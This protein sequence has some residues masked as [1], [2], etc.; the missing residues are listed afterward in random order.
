MT[1]PEQ[2][3]R[4]WDE[5]SAGLQLLARA[6]CA[7]PEDCVQEAFIRLAG[8]S[9]SP[10]DPAAWLARVVRNLAIDQSRSEQRR[11]R[12]EQEFATDYARSLQAVD[13]YAAGSLEPADVARAMAAL[14]VED[15]EIVSAYLWGRL[16]FR[17]I[18]EAFELSSSAVHRRYTAAIESM[19]EHLGVRARK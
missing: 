10:N 16:S 18:A 11:K 14:N 19:R 6:R 9:E 7:S 4:L 15:R 3:I 17:Q 1:A 2:L 5:H 12:R 8:R 13:P